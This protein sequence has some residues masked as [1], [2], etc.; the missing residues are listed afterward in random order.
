KLHIEAGIKLFCGKILL[1]C[2]IMSIIIALIK[3]YYLEYFYSEYLLIKVCMLG[4][5]IAV[6]M[7]AFFGT[8]YLLKVVNYDNNKK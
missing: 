2:I 4:G 6:G 5:T 7:G 3:Y 1:C 8:A